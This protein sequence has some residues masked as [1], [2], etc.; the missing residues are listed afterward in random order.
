M[1]PKNL[2]LNA[3]SDSWYDK[4]FYENNDFANSI[5]LSFNRIFQFDCII[6]VGFLIL[7]IFPVLFK[8]YGFGLQQRLRHFYDNSRSIFI[9]FLFLC[10]LSLSLSTIFH[11][12]VQ[13]PMPCI[14]WDGRNVLPTTLGSR[15]P[16][17]ELIITLILVESI[18]SLKIGMNFL[19][20]LISL[21]LLLS[22]CYTA[23][24]TGSSSISQLLVSLSLGFWIIFL[25]KFLPPIG[26]P[27]TSIIS[28]LIV[29]FLFFYLFPNFGWDSSLMRE[30][31]QIC[32]RSSIV[33][34]CS[35]ILQI[36]FAFVRVEFDWFK[37]NWGFGWNSI[38][39]DSSDDVIVPSM[40]KETPQDDFGRVLTS[41]LI[42]G[43]ITFFLFLLGNTL[44][45]LSDQKFKFMVE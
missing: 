3:I 13:Q 28:S 40:L 1:N 22:D 24:L 19:R 11:L 34:I 5:A 14:I 10:A 16:N 31:L 12:W 21:I 20:K 23:L 15:T 38:Q 9:N 8:I 2:I 43:I 7:I 26:L 17:E 37:L 36:R 4:C 25:F 32:I 30:S 18:W 27:I 35:L 42:D 45:F 39:T 41:D 44:L 33:L 29:I 6:T